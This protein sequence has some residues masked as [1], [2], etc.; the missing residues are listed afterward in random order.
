MGR[1]LDETVLRAQMNLSLSHSPCFFSWSGTNPLECL[2]SKF[3]RLAWHQCGKRI[4]F[5]LLEGT[6]H[7][8]CENCFI[9]WL[10][11]QEE[12][13]FVCHIQVLTVETISACV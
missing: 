8:R 12:E 4:V 3:K 9:W 7:A 11:L 5:V 13:Q 1:G 2:V 10:S 6:S